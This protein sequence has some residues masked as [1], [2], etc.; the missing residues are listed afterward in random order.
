MKLTKYINENYQVLLL[1]FKKITHNHQSSQ[2]LLNDCLLSF[3][4]KGD[5][6]C[7]KVLEDGKVNEYLAKMGKTQY[8]SKT[9]PFYFRYRNPNQTKE[10]DENSEIEEV[11]EKKV[12]V[13][14]LAKDIKIYITGLN[15][16]ERTVAERH[17]GGGISQRELSRHYNI[18]RIHIHKTITEIRTNIKRGFNKKDYETD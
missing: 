12:D 1:L 4:E 18:N 3:L 17:F 6:Y 9:S 13:E 14:E 11:V 8:N 5:V 7:N 10:L 2:D 15:I 16:Y